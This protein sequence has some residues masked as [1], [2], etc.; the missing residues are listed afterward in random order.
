MARHGSLLQGGLTLYGA[1]NSASPSSSLVLPSPLA[2]DVIRG[3]GTLG[4]DHPGSRVRSDARYA[5]AAHREIVSIRAPYAGSDMPPRFCIAG[6]SWF[7]SALPRGERPAVHA[8]CSPSMNVSIRAPARGAT[9]PL[10]PA[11]LP[12]GERQLHSLRLT[13][14]RRFDPRS[15]SGSDPCGRSS[16]AAEPC[17]GPRSRLGSDAHGAIDIRHG[18]VSIRAPARGATVG[19]TRAGCR[20]RWFRSALPRGEQLCPPNWLQS[21]Q[22]FRSALPRGERPDV[23]L[24][25]DNAIVVSI[26]TPARGATFRVVRTE[27][28]DTFRSA[29][30][31]GERP[32]GPGPRRGRARFDPRS[33]AGSDRASPSRN[34]PVRLFRSALPRGERPPKSSP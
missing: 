24:V 12:R 20:P 3:D 10:A 4:V 27:L 5:S 34:T 32:A 19:C 14:R 9:A 23:D 21:W 17:F 29:L 6:S 28:V 30:P 1:N 26:R 16:A 15:R 7:R 2:K 33:R 8:S 25:A 18:L 31:R 11:A 22:M 13:S